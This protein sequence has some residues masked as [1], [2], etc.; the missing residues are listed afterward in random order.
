MNSDVYM[1]GKATAMIS[2]TNNQTT[3][4]RRL[5]KDLFLSLFFFCPAFD[6][7]AFPR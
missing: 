4:T 5:E 7:R 2:A 3:F 6:A 1:K